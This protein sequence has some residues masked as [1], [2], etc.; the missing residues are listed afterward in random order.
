MYADSTPV[1]AASPSHTRHGW[2]PCPAPRD[3]IELHD[4][5]LVCDGDP[6]EGPPPVRKPETVRTYITARGVVVE[7]VA[8][9]PRRH[10]G[11]VAP[12][13]PD[14]KDAPRIVCVEEEV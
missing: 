4:Q 10:A 1:V 3:T 7:R 9:T 2:P 8:R 5:P 14:R 12:L 6:V 13:S 11:R